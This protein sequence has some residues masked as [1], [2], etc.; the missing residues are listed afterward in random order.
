[1]V[2]FPSV[3]SNSV[4]GVGGRQVY[5][6]VAYVFPLENY[7]LEIIEKKIINFLVKFLKS[8]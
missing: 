2:M 4:E 6:S 8:I 5:I 7:F 3:V 1:M